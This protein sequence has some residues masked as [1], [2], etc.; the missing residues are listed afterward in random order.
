MKY[1]NLEK[2]IWKR[3]Q[4]TKNEIIPHSESHWGTQNKMRMENYPQCESQCATEL[5]SQNHMKRATG[6]C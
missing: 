5:G 4:K 6:S 3:V 2:K 1:Q